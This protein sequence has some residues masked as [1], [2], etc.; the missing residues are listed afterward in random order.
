MSNSNRILRG[1]QRAT[2]VK[3]LGDAIKLYPA[4]RYAGK[5]LISKPGVVTR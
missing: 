5:S 1:E 2:T 4:P 3:C